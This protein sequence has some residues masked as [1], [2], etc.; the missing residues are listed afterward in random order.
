MREREDASC[1][2]AQLGQTGLRAG[3]VMMV[4]ELSSR[5]LIGSVL[6]GADRSWRLLKRSITSMSSEQS[7]HLI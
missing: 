3:L 4:Q 7:G 1:A 2:W 6:G 5:A